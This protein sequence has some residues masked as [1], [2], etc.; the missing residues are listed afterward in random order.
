MKIGIKPIK[1]IIIYVPLRFLTF[2]QQRLSPLQVDGSIHLTL[3]Q[4]LL[5][6]FKLNIY[7]SII[8][9]TVYE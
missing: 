9:H 4:T 1:C 6:N 7:I 2:L 8:F 5:H 3:L